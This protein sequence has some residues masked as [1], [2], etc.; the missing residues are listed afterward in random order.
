VSNPNWLDTPT[1]FAARLRITLDE[2]ATEG[3]P[4][5]VSLNATG[6]DLEAHSV[7]D[8]AQNGADISGVVMVVGRVRTVSASPVTWTS[9][10]H[11]TRGPKHDAVLEAP[12]KRSVIFGLI[13]GKLRRGQ[14]VY[15]PGV[16][17]AVGDTKS[18]TATAYVVSVSAALTR[19][20]TSGAIQVLIKAYLIALK[21]TTSA[22]G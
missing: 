11:E 9:G 14:I 10:G 21:Q 5:A 16:V 3:H 13:A 4:A 7:E 22:T 15:F 1:T 12:D 20:P 17:V 2:Q 8:L 6:T 18:R 19:V